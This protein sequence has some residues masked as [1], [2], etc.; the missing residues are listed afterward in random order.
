MITVKDLFE[1]NELL[2]SIVDDLE[3]VHEDTPVTY[4]VWVFRYNKNGTVSEFLNGTFDDPDEA[5]NAAKNFELVPIEG[6]SEEERLYNVM[7]IEVET[8]IADPDV[9]DGGTI[10]IGTIYQRDLWPDSPEA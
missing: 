9:D 10:N 5:I 4:E 3:N 7:S 8:V 6:L 1:N 2:D